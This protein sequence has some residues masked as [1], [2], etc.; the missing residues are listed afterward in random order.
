MF[1]RKAMVLS[2]LCLLVACSTINVRQTA[3]TAYD[4]KGYNN[5]RWK[6]APLDDPAKYAERAVILDKA[7]RDTVGAE[8]SRRGISRKAFNE[9]AEL[10]LDYKVLFQPESY[11]DMDVDNFGWVW[12]RDESGKLQRHTV[13]PA[14]E[15]VVLQRARLVL[16]VTDANQKEILWEVEADRLMDQG[17]EVDGDDMRQSLGEVVAKMFE[18]FP[19]GE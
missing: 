12:Q 2:A 14:D 10:V 8:M 6:L 18:L 17:R 4:L 7:M 9:P 1:L 3:G 11:A 13:N 16:T 5:Y 15:K 19:K